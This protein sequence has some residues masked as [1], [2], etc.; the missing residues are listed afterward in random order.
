[1][2]KIVSIVFLQGL[3]LVGMTSHP[4]QSIQQVMYVVTLLIL[5]GMLAVS[6]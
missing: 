3:C 6:D 1:M 2:R 5:G 4:D